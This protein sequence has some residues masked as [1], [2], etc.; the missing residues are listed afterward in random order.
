MFSKWDK[1]RERHLFKHEDRN[2]DLYLDP[3]YFT[4]DNLIKIDCQIK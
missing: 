3:M 1:G 4:T 2:L